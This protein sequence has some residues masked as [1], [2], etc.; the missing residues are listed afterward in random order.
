MPMDPLGVHCVQGMILALH[1]SCTG[2][3]NEL[4]SGS[5]LKPSQAA[6][7][8]GLVLRVYE[9]RLEGLEIRVW[10]LRLRVNPEP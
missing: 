3:I 2:V 4:H 9:F 7:N 10:A 8:V 5:F 6:S 1:Q